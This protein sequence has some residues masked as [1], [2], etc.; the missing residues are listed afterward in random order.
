MER[1]SR[2]RRSVIIGT[3]FVLGLVT[4]AYGGWTLA[5]SDFDLSQPWSPAVCLVLAGL[6]LAAMLFGSIALSRNMDEV[7]RQV[8]YRAAGAAGGAYAVVYPT[9]FLLW[10]G[11]FV[12]EPVHW[13]FFILFWVVLAASTIYYRYR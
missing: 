3:L 6:Y 11:G 1:A 10:K 5:A 13:A 8:H 12:G 9:W 7:E 2:R 4:G